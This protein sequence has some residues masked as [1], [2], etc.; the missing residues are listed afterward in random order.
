MQHA[1]PPYPSPT[2]G[3]CSNSCPSSWWCHPAISF[4]VILVSSCL[5]SFS[6]SG[7]FP[8]SWLFVSGGQSIRVSASA[9]VL[10][11]NIQDWF[12]LGWT[13]LLAVQRTLKSLFQHHSSQA[14]TLQYSAFFT[15]T[16]NIVS[17]YIV[18]LYSLTS[19]HDYWKNHSFD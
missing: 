18:F 4:S 11:V 17:F 15:V 16:H 6:A 14:S 5:Q 9:S 7:Y 8:V 2:S 19:I 3:P 12:P 1:R 10:S 13:D